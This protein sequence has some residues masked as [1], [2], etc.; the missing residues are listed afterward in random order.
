MKTVFI[1]GAGANVE[2]GMPSGDDLRKEI[3]EILNFSEFRKG[4]IDFFDAMS[5]AIHEED[6]MYDIAS[7]IKK[8]LPY[9]ISIDNFLDVHR[10]EPNIILAGKLA[11]IYLIKKAEE[12]SSLYHYLNNYN[13]N[14]LNTWY[15]LFFQKI[16]EGNNITEFEERIKDMA[17]IIFNYD[18]C[19]EYYMIQ[20]LCDQFGINHSRAEN[21]VNKMDIIHP[22]GIIG[23]IEDVAI[24][25]TIT[26]FELINLT[27]NIRTFAENSHETRNKGATIQDHILN[28]SQIIFLG[29]GYH[30]MNLDLIF[31][32][33]KIKIIMKRCIKCYGTSLG[34]SEK[35]REHIEYRLKQLYPR[36]NICDIS[37]GT[38]TQFFKDFWHRISFR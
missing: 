8:A 14:I 27:G 13:K 3:A 36:I 19:F 26:P 1:I 32:D 31:K 6:K 12:K 20:A 16:T 35:Y 25:K 28:A 10:S 29:F 9:S 33:I 15:L 21:I 2:I 24:G 23:K 38:C 7:T 22:Y 5:K 30:P 37:G 4:N 34:I 18:R 11:I 17:F